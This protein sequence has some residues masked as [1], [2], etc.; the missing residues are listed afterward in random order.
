VPELPAK[1]SAAAEA[2]DRFSWTVHPARERPLTTLGISAMVLVVG[3]Y[4][5]VESGLLIVGIG[6]MLVLVLFW[7]R[8]FF[9]SS[10]SIDSEGLSESGVTGE[11]RLL[12]QDV[13]LAQI[14]TQ[15][16]WLSEL[17]RRN[18]REGRRGI[19]VLFGKQR[20][21]VVAEMTRYLPREILNPAQIESSPNTNQSSKR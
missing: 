18:W 2:T 11:K 16:A 3:G 21:R 5:Q 15:A 14:G 17:P 7:Q 6:A 13:R 20:E 4:V 9:P 10:Y 8:F 19:H 1:D 12:W